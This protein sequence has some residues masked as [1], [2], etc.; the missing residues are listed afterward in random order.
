MSN[1]KSKKVSN[2][3]IPSFDDDFAV[4]MVRCGSSKADK[5]FMMDNPL[6]SPEEMDKRRDA[7]Q[8]IAKHEWK[9]EVV[10]KFGK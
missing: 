4:R 9:N 3:V 10:A 1:I 8:A 6:F 2:T 7:R 5:G